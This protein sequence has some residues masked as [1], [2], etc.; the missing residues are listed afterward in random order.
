MPGSTSSIAAAIAVEGLLLQ[1][2]NSGT[3]P[4]AFFTICNVSDFTLPMTSKT[5]DI[6]N[7]GDKWE[8]MIPTLLSFGKITLKVFWVMEEP[9][10][11]NQA[12]GGAVA[13]GLR[14]LW[15]NQ[16]LRDWQVIY[17]DGN[18]STD[19]FSAYVTGFQITGK[20]A[21]TFDATIELTANTGGPSLV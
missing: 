8:R 7:V 14:Y 21:G 16:L 20:V 1:V 11:R 18:N 6:T 4:D 17:P 19:A 2:S 13:V 5:T 3:S 12:G 10:H 9:T 15:I